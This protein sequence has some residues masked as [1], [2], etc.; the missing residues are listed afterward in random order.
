MLTSTYSPSTPTRRCSGNIAPAGPREGVS[1]DKRGRARVSMCAD[2]SGTCA[3]ARTPTTADIRKERAW[4]VCHTET[5]LQRACTKKA[6]SRQREEVDKQRDVP[7]TGTGRSARRWL[8]RYGTWRCPIRRFPE[9]SCRG[10]CGHGKP[11]RRRKCCDLHPPI[12]KVLVGIPNFII[13]S[14]NSGKN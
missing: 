13:R 10:R 9:A 8:G 2:T 7:S 5:R 11:A 4:A 3:V 1:G 12:M 6:I 14:D